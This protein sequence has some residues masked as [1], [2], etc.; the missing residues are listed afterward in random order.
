MRSWLP[1]HSSSQGLC[2]NGEGFH[3]ALK[4]LTGIYLQLFKFL[5]AELI[6]LSCFVEI[7]KTKLKHYPSHQTLQARFSAFSFAFTEHCQK[8]QSAQQQART[9]KSF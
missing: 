6:W 7:F 5:L 9:V 4:L 8:E 1:R 2:P 3:A